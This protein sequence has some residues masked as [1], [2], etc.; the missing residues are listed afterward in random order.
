[1]DPG[2]GQGEGALA[3]WCGLGFA[4]RSIDRAAFTMSAG[5][6]KQRENERGFT[7]IET[8]V[9]LALTGLVLS[10]LANITA[11]WLP[12]WNRGVDR[13]QQME[14]IAIAMQRIAADVSAA[15]YVPASRERP[16]PLFDGSAFS[17]TFVRTASGRNGG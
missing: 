3:F 4:H 7:L 5:L 12:N 13:I 6:A 2:T 15:E 10:A 8:L 11:Q 16:Q 9:A 1:M 17:V 14:S